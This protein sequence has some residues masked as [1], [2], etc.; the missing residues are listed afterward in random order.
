MFSSVGLLHFVIYQELTDEQAEE[1]IFLSTKII[2]YF[3]LP[4]IT[5]FRS[6][7]LIYYVPIMSC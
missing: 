1:S 2:T 3:E 4:K 5:K 6:L 7:V